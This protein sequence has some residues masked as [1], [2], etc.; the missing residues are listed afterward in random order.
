LP[1]IKAAFIETN[2]IPIKAA[3]NMAGLPAGPVRPPLAPLS[4]SSKRALEAALPAERVYLR[5][6]TGVTT[7]FS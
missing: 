5:D 4:E 1:F 3:L 7:S 6:A 2:P